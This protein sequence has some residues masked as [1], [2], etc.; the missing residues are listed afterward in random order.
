MDDKTSGA[1]RKTLLH[2]TNLRNEL[3]LRKSEPIA[4]VGFG[5]RFPGGANNPEAFWRMLEAGVDGICDIP[6]ERFD[7]N[8]YY[9][10][11]YDVPGKMYTHKAGFLNVP[12]DLFDADFFGISPKEAED[13]DPQQRL[14]LEVSWEALEHAAID[15][16]HL[17]G[18][19]TG[20]YVGIMNSDY[21]QLIFSSKGFDGLSAYFSSG[22]AF[23]AAVGRV[24]YVLGLQGPCLAIDTAC[25]SSLVAINSACESLRSGHCQQALAGGV[26]LLL[27]PGTFIGGCQAHMLSPDGHCKTFD[28]SADGY[29]RAEGC[30]M[31]VLKRLS[32]AQRDGDTIYAV[33][34]NSGVNQGG[35]SGG[36][37]V[38]NGKA[39]EM[40]LRMVYSDIGLK[41]DDIDYIEAH[42][43]GTSLGDP[44][45]VNALKGTYGKRDTNH[46]LLLGSVKSN[47]G[48]AEPAAGIAGV[49]KVILSLNHQALPG[50]LGF[51]KLNPNIDLNFPV[52]ILTQM[53]PWP[54]SDRVRRAGVSSFGFSGSNAHV[55]IEEAPPFIPKTLASEEHPSHLFTLSAKSDA[56][57]DALL[58]TYQSYLAE[59]KDPLADICYTLHTGRAHHSCRIAVVANDVPDLM[60]KLSKG[61]LFRGLSRE[62][63]TYAFDPPVNSEDWSSAL[64]QF[65]AVYV[66]GAICDW[67][68]LESSFACKKLALPTYSF[69][70]T[71]YWS[72]AI[73]PVKPR[74]T[75]TPTEQTPFIVNSDTRCIKD[76]ILSIFS[77][78][79]YLP[80]TN[81]DIE[82]D[83]ADYGLDSLMITAMNTK[84]ES[85]FGPLSVTLLYKLR[86]LQQ[87]IDY[88]EQEKQSEYRTY[89][90]TQFVQPASDTVK[91]NMDVAIIGMSGH[92]PLAAD[93]I[94]FWENLKTGRDCITSIPES[95][96][97]QLSSPD[98]KW[99][100]FIEGVDQFD[101][102]FFNISPADAKFM[103]P[104]ERLF[105][106]E[107]WQCIE[108]GG[109]RPDSLIKK[110]H[111]RVGV[112]VGVS[113]N[114]Y[115]LYTNIVSSADKKTPANMQTFSV[116]NRVSYF[117]NFTGPSF[118]VDTACSS[119][120]YAIH[121]ALQSI[122]QGECQVALAGGVNLS[123]H[124]SKFEGL[125][126]Y[127]FLASDG[128]CHS[129]GDGGDG[130]VP[131]EGVGAILLKPLEQAIA[132]KDN[133]LGVIK[134][135]GVSQGGKSGGYYV[136]NPVAQTEAINIAL[137]HAKINP[138]SISYLE[139][140]G[141]GTPLGDPIEITGLEDAYQP[142]T[143]DKQFC[144]IGSVK[145][146]IGHAEGAAGI[147]Q[148][149]KV[150]LQIQAK[151][152]A[153]NLIHSEH[154]N[155]KI[156][157]SASPFYVPRE[158]HPWTPEG[159][160]PRRAGISSF[161]AGGV[162]VHLII[163]EY[164]APKTHIE[165]NS[166]LG[167]IYAIPLSAKKI[168]SLQDAVTQLYDFLYLRTGSTNEP[169]FHDIC[170]EDL[171]YT[172]QVGRVAMRYRIVLLVN[173][174]RQL[175]EEL[176]QLANNPVLLQQRIQDKPESNP[177]RVDLMQVKDIKSIAEDWLRGASVHWEELYKNNPRQRIYLPSYSFS[178]QSCWAGAR[179]NDAPSLEL[180][181]PSVGVVNPVQTVAFKK[182]PEEIAIIRQSD[183]PLLRSL[184][185]VPENEQREILTNYMQKLLADTLE[186]EP[187]NLPGVDLGFFEMGISS[188]QTIALQ[189]KIERDLNI[190]LSE[191][192]IFDY[193]NLNEFL[194]YVMTLL[195]QDLNEAP[196]VQEAIE[197]QQDIDSAAHEDDIAI[198]GMSCRFPGGCNT[199]EQ[200]WN[201]IQQ[202][203]DAITEMPLERWD[204]NKYYS[205]EVDAPGCMYVRE[206]GFIQQKIDEFD[207]RLFGVSSAEAIDMDPQQRILLEL[208]WEA[209][210]NSNYSPVDL[211]GSKT[212]VFIGMAVP[213]YVLLPE[214][215]KHHDFTKISPYW[216]TGLITSL[217]SGRV[218]HHFGLQG[219]A[220]TMDTACSS[221]LV[222]AHLACDSLR[223]G[224]CD[225]ALAGGVSLML[226]PVTFIALCR[227]RALAPDGRCKTFDAAGD[228][229]GRSEGA[230]IIVLKRYSTALRDGDNI[231]AVIKGGA[232]NQDGK[233]S[234]LT[235]PNGQ[236]QRELIKEALK[237]A[238]LDVNDIT[239]LEAHGTGTPLGDPIEIG[240]VT[241][242]LGHNRASDNPLYLGAVKRNIG[243]TE[244]A[245][246]VAGIIKSVLCLQ[247]KQIPALKVNQLNPKINLDVIPAIIPNELMDW[248]TKGRERTMGISSFGFSGTNAHL[249]LSEAPSLKNANNTV[250]RRVHVVALSGQTEAA[251]TEVI[252]SLKKYL[253]H[254]DATLQDIAFSANT[255]H[256]HFPYRLAV[257]ADSIPSLI[258][259]IDSIGTMPEQS[260][261]KLV[262]LFAAFEGE[263]VGRG[264]EL[265][266]R[267]PTFKNAIMDL[268]EITMRSMQI[269][270]SELILNRP[271]RVLTTVEEQIAQFVL[272]Q[273]LFTLWY[274]WGIRPDGV[275]GESTGAYVAAVV[276]GIMDIET[277]LILLLNIKTADQVQLNQPKI[278]FISQ[279]SGKAVKSSEVVRPDYWNQQQ[280]LTIRNPEVIGTLIERGYN[281]YLQI[282]PG[283]ALTEVPH[284][285]QSLGAE[286]DEST[287]V[288]SLA[289]LYNDGI[290]VDWKGFDRDYQRNKIV[291]PNYPFQRKHYWIELD[292]SPISIKSSNPANQFPLKGLSL[293]QGD[294]CFGYS[295]S[296]HNLSVINDTHGVVHVG[297]FQEM[298]LS[299]LRTLEP[300][301]QYQVNQMSFLLPLMLDEEETRSVM[302]V[303]VKEEE[304]VYQF[305]FLSNQGDD[306]KWTLHTQGQVS[307]K[308]S[309]ILNESLSHP[310][311]DTEPVLY[312]NTSFYAMMAARGLHLGKRVK[313]VDKVWNDNDLV[314]A[315]FNL[316]SDDLQTEQYTLPFDPSILDV[317]AQLVH[318]ALPS[319]APA[320]L[321]MMVVSWGEYLTNTT[322]PYHELWYQL[323]IHNDESAKDQYVGDF[324]VTNE[325]GQIMVQ[326]KQCRMQGFTDA[327]LAA[328]RQAMKHINKDEHAHKPLLDQLLAI[329][330]D[331]QKQSM[332]GIVK[333]ILAKL[334][335]MDQN[336]MAVEESIFN[337]G[338]DSIVAMSFR[339]ELLKQLG[340]D[341]PVEE[342]LSGPT[343]NNLA[344]TIL[345]LLPQHEIKSIAEASLD[346]GRWFIGTR[347]PTAKLRLFCL[348]YGG[349]G[350]QIY[351]EW[352][353]LMPDEIDV[354]PIQL[355]GRETRIKEAPYTDINS[356]LADLVQAILPEL[357][358]PYALFG[359]S[360]GGLLAYTLADYLTHHDQR[361]PAQVFVSAYTSLS[362]S[363]PRLAELMANMKKYGLDLMNKE[364]SINDE[365]INLIIE[366]N[367]LP[368]CK[369]MNPVILPL[370][371]KTGIPD[372]QVVH[373]FV[374]NNSL[375]QCN[376]S[377]FYG[378]EDE[379]VS[380][381]DMK[382]WILLTTK[383][384]E[385]HQMTGDHLFINDAI[386]RDEMIAIIKKTLSS[387]WE[388][389]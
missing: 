229:Y 297:L 232:I 220:I 244:A 320:D 269:N 95:R 304:S 88:F 372:L 133:I 301:S 168:D 275:Y 108:S 78:A 79:T 126:K 149:I 364:G 84:L 111:D 197:E 227:V 127:G 185:D 60:Q 207:A 388:K 5:C 334:L 73:E 71:R 266:Q 233:S 90:D 340:I 153:P 259:R 338:I 33:I 198:I 328:L 226:T 12:V 241:E 261:R 296:R 128:R 284:Y 169:L 268:N 93:V 137:E 59:T 122:V 46:P 173:S 155:S 62:H 347:K 157:F 236:A 124:P 163:D 179:F 263:V 74:I 380:A 102:D 384:F 97:H 3:D 316:P 366:H 30:G 139:A 103:T 371:I 40:L 34:R 49:I 327:I 162:N 309:V 376:L 195:P 132:D 248:D 131:S 219:P 344:D 351:R 361:I 359:H 194:G 251:R 260:P 77:E 292:N 308:P 72:R 258:E 31:I 58:Q 123:L 52:K 387:I 281:E 200:F 199:P 383:D 253:Q 389:L 55:I 104:N 125:A 8:D 187:P 66:Q 134:G 314:I 183:T 367:L 87:L 354:I 156:D 158:L 321:K 167:I 175:V 293:P 299:A 76:I 65:A 188:I 148:V 250:D 294:H 6:K 56:A 246:G 166:S 352:Q 315:K 35:A 206:G 112:F 290:T 174:L 25:S 267:F 201:L 99:G 83:F 159:A 234:G 312:D 32:D 289:S 191:T 225:M 353:S 326:C 36:L 106:Q 9:D 96:I 100:G 94:E 69:Q 278:S 381:N 325:S 279:Q 214:D 348:P 362:I 37:T 369:N 115:G 154:L 81:I 242:V 283:S 350:A 218:A 164:N 177:G 130:Y 249:I 256:M 75:A 13:M 116:A 82:K 356:L 310:L 307:I 343:T 190:K 176:R 119:S 230:G 109:Y 24:S 161:G 378:T 349:G 171:A 360:F 300:V 118:T 385:M 285:Y 332:I 277:A 110:P 319:N 331:Q 129:F 335:S 210:E 235:V 272:Q 208:A 38:P 47:F 45:E 136:P 28:E 151:Q 4:V 209:F 70:R 239:Y 26:N 243:H 211:I 143:S 150:L 355:P 21:S 357:D 114:D 240:S 358:R 346:R 141:T 43:T 202:A 7:F 17:S 61:E 368:E 138:R 80:L 333:E 54:E 212:G 42:G 27:S 180:K 245:S 337:F 63:K 48:H 184:V 18:S 270:V 216:A 144:A 305:K 264:M 189:Q 170:L 172:L 44:I 365:E 379:T 113:I 306:A 291:L 105:L 186:Y 313:L 1:I 203:G 98:V 286:G 342:L 295:I 373:S 107:A 29:A 117:C 140:H 39:Q 92:F 382:A 11:A 86:N 2:V 145:S 68:L 91:K 303:L 41:P 22:N 252:A 262:M 182:A 386:C 302:L 67:R 53:T 20:L 273:A 280:R 121:L 345:H 271:E 19:M 370:Y 193:P 339:N 178:T 165:D 152:I 336:E 375:L 322:I 257:T 51:K 85:V 196:M 237:N 223:R 205:K 147:S 324:I 282:N 213:E 64:A 16:E 255:G 276:A 23:S 247:H 363:N 142:V 377:V 330:G 238:N 374:A 318:V 192:A 89:I 287:L 222:S 311:K 221:S 254:T 135:S 50:N 57:L 323:K 10:A 160:N 298:L 217:A 341:L 101:F 204:V 224:E 228:G 181:K 215:K 14:L 15:P 317:C 146:N 329:H 265:S 120:L 231:L 274:S 288:Q